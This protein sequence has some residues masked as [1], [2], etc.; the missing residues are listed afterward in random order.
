[1]PP[2]H[3][4]RRRSSL[5]V[6]LSVAAAALLA[7]PENS[8]PSPLAAAVSDTTA[9][10]STR[11]IWTRDTLAG[12]S[13]ELLMRVL[14]SNAD[15]GGASFLSSLFGAEAAARPGVYVTDADDG[16]P[17]TF[18]NLVPFTEKQRGRVGTYRMGSWPG[19]LRT[20]S[21]NYGNPAG[22]IEVT[23]ENRDTQ[24][25][26]HFR[27]R[28]FLTKDQATVWPKYLV[29]QEGLLDK[30]ELV[31][32]E[33]RTSGH[34][35]SHMTVMS[36]FRTPQYN[37]QGVGSGGR[38]SASRHQYGDAADVFVDNDRNGVM[39]DL[40]GDGRVNTRDAQV[41]A[42]AAERVESRHPELVGGIGIYPANSAHGPFV[43][44]DVRGNRARW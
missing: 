17:F 42:Q 26:R 8:R 27:L 16:K 38:A 21:P 43:H 39:D 29:L 4:W 6:S 24:V 19:E 20:M 36:G 40:N 37:E 2:I 22:F 10:D 41:L 35:V 31:I 44:V 11:A 23:L 25:S 1:M 34:R 3:T 9:P 13:G 15:S 30:L 33:L 28:D 14:A 12:R 7:L 32:H 18:V 5:L